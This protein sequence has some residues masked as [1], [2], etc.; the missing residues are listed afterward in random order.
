MNIKVNSVHFDADQKLI[1][2]IE[3]KV[4]KLMQYSDEILSAEVFLRLANTQEPEN[5]ITE[6][7]LGYP[8][9][10]LFAKK[11]S[12]SFEESTDN[13]IEALKRQITKQKEKVKRG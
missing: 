1:N 8:G 11:Q 2:F 9:G 5:K 3:K 12:K 13:V 7:R 10:D 6:I 4:G